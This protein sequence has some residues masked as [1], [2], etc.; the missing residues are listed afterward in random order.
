LKKERGKSPY[1]VV[2]IFTDNPESNAKK[3][4]EKILPHLEGKGIK[5]KVLAIGD[6]PP[7]DI[8]HSN[9]N[10]NCSLGKSGF[11]VAALSR[12]WTT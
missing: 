1:E 11:Y 5:A 12:L 8:K 2:L 6:F 4:V 9:L 7:I 10:Y 3:I